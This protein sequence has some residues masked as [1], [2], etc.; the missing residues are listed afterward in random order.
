M[1]S[2]NIVLKTSFLV[3]IWYVPVHTPQ[4]TWAW[5][6]IDMF[7]YK[8]RGTRLRFNLFLF[9]YT[10]LLI[11]F[12]HYLNFK[13]KI[14]FLICIWLQFWICFRTSFTFICLSLSDNFIDMYSVFFITHTTNVRLII[15]YTWNCIHLE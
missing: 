9:A 7:C 14:H 15:L 13:C 2:W 10:I 12:T 5:F 1:Y 6:Y 3:S 8:H 4:N 11:L